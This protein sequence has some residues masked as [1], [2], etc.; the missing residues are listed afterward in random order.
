MLFKDPK[1]FFLIILEG[2]NIFKTS[3]K[4]FLKKK[5]ILINLNPELVEIN[6]PPTKV[7]KS[8]INEKFWKEL[9]AWTIPVLEADN[10][11]DIKISKKLVILGY[12][13]INI[14]GV[15]IKNNKR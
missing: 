1:I 11:K 3:V 5:T 14:R 12:K 2:T 10:A 4:N 15:K 8:K 13:I 9:L 7:V 6:D